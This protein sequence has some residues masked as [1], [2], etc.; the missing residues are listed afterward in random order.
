MINPFIKYKGL[1]LFG[2]YEM[3]KGR[4]ITEKSMRTATQYALDLIYRFPKEKENFWL[5]DATILLQQRCPS[6]RAM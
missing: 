2:A 6:I 5:A 4:T 1:E 3:A